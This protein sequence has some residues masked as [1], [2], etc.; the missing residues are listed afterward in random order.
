MTLNGEHTSKK[1]DLLV[2]LLDKKVSCITDEL[3]AV[4]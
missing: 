2:V 1:D 4:G 3:D